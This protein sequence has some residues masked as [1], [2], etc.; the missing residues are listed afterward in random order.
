MNHLSKLQ[1]QVKAYKLDGLLLT[2]SSGEFYA[3]GIHS[4]AVAIITP[5]HCLLATDGRYTEVVANQLEKEGLDQV[6]LQRAQGKKTRL[7]I[8]RDFILQHGLREMGFE[9]EY[10]SVSDHRRYQQE[11]PCNLIDT[12]V[13]LKDL[14]G[15]KSPQEQQIMKD[16]Q[17]IADGA[18]LELLNFVQVGRTEQE[19]AAQIAY[20]M[21]KRGGL[22][23][24]FPCIIASGSNGSRPHAVPTEKP[25]QTGEFI[26]MDFGCRYQG[27]C[28]DMTRTIALGEISEEMHTVYHTVLDAQE[29]AI[30]NMKAGMTGQEIDQLARTVI[31]KSGYG[32][33]FSHSLGH[34]VG[35]EIHET[36]N[37]SQS[38]IT[39]LP[40]GVMI[41]VEPGIYIPEKFGVRIEDVVI[42]TE[43]ACE[44]ITFSQ[45]KLITL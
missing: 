42:I 13:I 38:D 43:T 34:S 45:K 35:L 12:Q 3:F 19:I 2:S 1:E 29:T 20:E 23:L 27:Y 33:Y 40:A 44:N 8:A 16:A 41:S 26:T 28:S 25:V 37:A 30:K 9:G 5:T 22:E 11:L 15:V 36:P 17:K 7:T 39:N 4:E 31:E 32:E 10:V 14:R 24:S 6:T 21:A 18:F